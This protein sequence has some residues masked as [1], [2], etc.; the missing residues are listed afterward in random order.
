MYRFYA[1]SIPR[2]IYT[3][4]YLW[5]LEHLWIWVAPKPPEAIP[6]G[7]QRAERRPGSRNH[8]SCCQGGQ[9]ALE[10]GEDKLFYPLMMY[11]CRKTVGTSHTTEHGASEI[12][13]L[14]SP[15]FKD[16][17]RGFHV[18]DC[19]VAEVKQPRLWLRWSSH[20]RFLGL[21]GWCRWWALWAHSWVSSVLWL[22]R[23]L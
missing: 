23:I 4:I 2:Y 19:A 20:V 12:K 17:D 1:N 18:Q 16:E 5:G 7:Y 10:M 11:S 22:M 15:W 3:L 9:E 14:P 13:S 8:Y 21:R 6:H